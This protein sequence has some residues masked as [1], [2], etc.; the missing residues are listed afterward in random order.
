MKMLSEKSVLLF[1]VAL[2]VGAFAAPMAAAASW[3]VVGTTHQLTSNNLQFSQAIGGGLSI[4]ASCATAQFDTDVTSASRL[5]ITGGRFDNCIGTGIAAGCTVTSTKTRFP[6]TVTA[7]T[8][9]TIQ[10]HG[11][12]IDWWFET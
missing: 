6:W 10:I 11:V 4:G 2:A 9:T 5:T 1:G 3:S 8:T 7:P 12:H